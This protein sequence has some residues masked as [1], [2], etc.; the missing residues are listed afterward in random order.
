MDYKE[1]N[2]QRAEAQLR[3][4]KPN[5]GHA[6][7]LRRRLGLG[8][9][10]VAPPTPPAPVVEAAAPTKKKTTKKKTKK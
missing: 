10:P 2:R 4:L 5:T 7:N 9:G 6:R 8:D 1:R 3:R